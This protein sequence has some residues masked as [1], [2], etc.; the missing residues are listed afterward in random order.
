VTPPGIDPGTIRLVAQY[1]N[2]YATLGPLFYLNPSKTPV[3]ILSSKFYLQPME[4]VSTNFTGVTTNNANRL[5]FEIQMER[6]LL[7]F[8]EC[9]TG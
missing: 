7:S 2:H 5:V 3:V 4:Y 9:N 8:T 1:L 6:V